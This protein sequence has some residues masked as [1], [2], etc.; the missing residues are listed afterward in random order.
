MATGLGRIL[1][2]KRPVSL[3]LLC[4]SMTLLLCLYSMAKSTWLWGM[5]LFNDDFVDDDFVDRADCMLLNPTMKS[6][7]CKDFQVCLYLD[8][9]V[10]LLRVLLLCA[11][12]YMCVCVCVYGCGCV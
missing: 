7:L 6:F 2:C 3:T 5:I 12:V 10:H 11:C 4:L 9:S 8:T 1:H